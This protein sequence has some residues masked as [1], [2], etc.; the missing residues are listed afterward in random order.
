MLAGLLAIASSAAVASAQALYKP[1]TPE[2]LPVGSPAW[3]QR[4]EKDPMG[5]NFYEMDSLFRSWMVSD[6]DAR[7]KTMA[8]KPAVNFYRRW[9]RAVRPYVTSSGRIVL[10]TLSEHFAQLDAMNARA[11]RASKFRALD[12][13]RWINIGPN[14]T[15]TK[16]DGVVKQKD[17]QVCVF[18][19]AVAPTNHNIVYAGT[20]TG[21]VF[22]TID[23]GQTWQAAAG[24]HNF[25]GSIY[26]MA[27]SPTN[28]NVVYVGGG[29]ALWK[30][31]DGG[32][33]WQREPNIAARVNSIRISPTNTDHITVATH[34]ES[35]AP[36]GFYH[37]TDGGRTYTR[38]LTGLCHDHELKPKDPQTVYLLVQESVDTP[39]VLRIST[40][41]GASFTER[42]VPIANIRAGRLAVSEAPGGENYVYALTT[43]NSNTYDRRPDGDAGGVPHL[44]KSVDSGRTWTDM[45]Q[46]NTGRDA[47][48]NTFSPFVDDTYGGQGYFDMMIGASNKDPEHVIFG[49][50]NAYRSTRGGAGRYLETAI[51]GYQALS[52]MH[53]DM[54][55]I[56]IAGDDCWI[57]TDGGI[58]YSSD[59]FATDGVD[60]NNGI[61]ASDYHGF[62]QGWNEDV[63]VGGRWHNGDVVHAASYGLGNTL[64]VGG[65]EWATGHV[66]LSNPRHVYFSDAGSYIA[67]NEL[68]G[69]LQELT[70]EYFS[71]KK[72][73]EALKSHGR[74]TFDPRYAQR[75]IINSNEDHYQLYESRDE[76]RSFRLLFDSDGENMTNVEFA[77]SNPNYIYVCGVWNIFRST[78][79]GATFQETETRPFPENHGSAPSILAVHPADERTVWVVNSNLKGAVAYTKDG[80]VTWSRVSSPIFADI[81]LHW[82][83]LTG[84]EKNGVYIGADTGTK[85]F[86]KDDTMPEWIDYSNGLNPGARITR[87][88]P[89]YKEGKL[90]AATDQGIWERPLKRA[91]FVPVAQPMAT[92]IGDGDLTATP[93]KEVQFESYSIVNQADVTWHWSFS[94]KPEFVS[95]P[96]A[97]NPRVRFGKPAHYDVTLTV[98]TPQGTHKRTMKDMIRI[99]SEPNKPDPNAINDVEKNAV[100][101]FPN[102]LSV[103]ESIEV[104]MPELTEEKT[105]TL[106]DTRGRLIERHTFSPTESAAK[107]STSALQQGV[108]IYELRTPTRKFFGKLLLR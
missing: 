39:F 93:N 97:R 16:K 49:L 89:F 68:S 27:V 60:R 42:V 17:S 34:H 77:R 2:P 78:D 50:C 52:K 36:G 66:M 96:T 38:T 85:I 20:Q 80:G 105:L 63:M 86:Y 12:A 58:K 74:I 28:P 6:V 3:L 31:V 10:P 62:D 8:N 75:L 101:L 91:Q 1:Y 59:F 67:P 104:R 83:I 18:R 37:S 64:Y 44:L 88:V 9:E 53:P 33:S 107:L 95:D 102:V 45:T 46:R 106:H 61:Y 56:A 98:T 57:T 92:N 24:H 7:V 90:R 94:P 26:A 14:A 87:L 21:V 19:I 82:V 48:F 22:K 72:P 84:D 4:I 73:Y 81:P 40:D 54:Q 35:N 103:G 41:G 47:R 79:N 30:S 11:E 25:G 15:Y 65:V 108:Y 99:G 71:T 76:G 32:E 43:V 69:D 70:R 55:D 29:Q 51:G 23:K 5:V 13:D 100:G